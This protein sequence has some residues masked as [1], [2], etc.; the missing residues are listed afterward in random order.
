MRSWSKS[1]IFFGLVILFIG[2][3][4]WVSRGNGN[5]DGTLLEKDPSLIAVASNFLGT[6][7]KLVHAFE[8]ETGYDYALVPGSTGQLYAQ[9]KYGAPFEIFLA[10]DRE[11]PRLLEE[12]GKAVTGSRF[13][14]AEGRLALYRPDGESVGAQALAGQ[15][16][17]ALAIANPDLAPYGIAAIQALSGLGL[18]RKM[19]DRLVF[20]ENVSQAFGFVE[21]GNAQMGFVA[22]AQLQAAGKPENSYWSLPQSLYE[23]IKQDAILITENTRSGAFFDFLRT[24]TARDII[25]NDGYQ[26]P[27]R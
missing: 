11:R 7:E 2:A 26:V 18:D 16:I 3:V 17:N 12:E 5:A 9:I 8:R 23:P 14:Y 1:L 20:A 6:A 25:E 22:L 4:F 27:E 13:T 10:A 19:N 24:A 21:T 15:D